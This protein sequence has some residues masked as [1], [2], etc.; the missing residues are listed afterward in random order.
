MHGDEQSGKHPLPGHQECLPQ[1][2]PSV[3]DT[4]HEAARGPTQIHRLDCTKGRRSDYNP[5]DGE[6]VVAFIDDMLMLAWAKTL[7]EAN[8]KTS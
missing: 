1:C 7:A 5:K 3:T 6:T 4:Q 8:D 2:G